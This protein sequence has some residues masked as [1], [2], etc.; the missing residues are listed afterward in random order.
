MKKHPKIVPT[1]YEIHPL[2][3]Q[4]WS[5]RSF[6][7]KTI[8]IETLHHLFEAASWAASSMNEQPWRFVFG[9]KDS[10]LFSLMYSTLAGGNQVWAKDAQVLIAVIA[11]T[12][13][14]DGSMNLH[15]WHDVGA[16]S[17]YLLLQAAELGILGH[18]MGGFK[19]DI[20]ESL[21]NIPNH[22]SIVSIIALGYP[23][24]HEVLPEPFQSREITPRTRKP[25]HTFVFDSIDKLSL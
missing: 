9:S 8:Q 15:A 16:A 2:L 7:K 12:H 23:D 13:F 22:C 17:T 6:A 18:Q 5:A 14:S 19:R 1:Q 20:A 10:E 3:L 25:I 24:S 21:L 4:R 11:N